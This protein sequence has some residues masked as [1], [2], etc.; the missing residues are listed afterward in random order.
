M[1]LFGEKRDISMFR[2]IN[3]E[4]MGNIISQQAAFYKY[5]PSQTNSNIYGEASQEKFYIGPVLLYCLI[6]IPES[7]NPV[8]DFGVNFSW[9]PIFQFLRDDLLQKFYDFN[10]NYDFGDIYGANY[11][12]QPGDIIYYQNSYYE[13]DRAWE[14]QYFLGKNP[15]YPND[16][17]PP[18]FNPGLGDFGY[19]VAVA[20]Q[21]HYVPAD[22]VGITLERM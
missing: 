1:A 6:D 21:T 20:C 18:G 16:T 15:D 8:D 5:R 2:H 9:K 14:T 4:L 19:N 12:P 22:K 11:V 3:R 13:V 17:Q 10:L 7:Q